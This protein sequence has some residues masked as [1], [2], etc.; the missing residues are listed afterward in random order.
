M[1]H[2]CATGLSRFL[3]LA[4]GV[5]ETLFAVWDQKLTTG[6]GRQGCGWLPWLRPLSDV[7][8]IPSINRHLAAAACG[9]ENAEVTSQACDLQRELARFGLWAI[10]S[11]L[12]VPAYGGPS[13][14]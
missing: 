3:L 6:P 14:W 9:T 5:A 11:R 7:P 1:C 4:V 2:K 10:H 8:G 12:T 13:R